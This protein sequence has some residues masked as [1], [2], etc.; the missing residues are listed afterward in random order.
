[1][2]ATRLKWVHT[3]QSDSL[4]HGLVVPDAMHE[5]AL[6]H[7]LRVLAGAR[8]SFEAPRETKM[9]AASRNDSRNSLPR[10]IGV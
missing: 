8:S 9:P 2:A 3:A 7:N 6:V 4:P 10:R 1:V 5:Q